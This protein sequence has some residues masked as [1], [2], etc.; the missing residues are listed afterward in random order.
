VQ[1][2]STPAHWDDRSETVGLDLFWLPLGAGGRSV[3]WNGRIF[4]GASALIE[5]RTAQELYHSALVVHLPPNRYVV[6][7]TPVWNV[8]SV[9]R[10]VVVE[11]PVGVRFAKRYAIGRY[12]VHCWKNG[13]IADVD[14]AVDSP[15]RLVTDAPSCRRA[16]AA[17]GAVP[18]L[19]WGRDERR[20]GEMWN[21]NSVVAWVLMR[22]G[23]DAASIHPPLHG[24]APGWTAGVVAG[25]F[26]YTEPTTTTE[27]DT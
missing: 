3:K 13:T 16:L 24:A 23:I 5:R 12:E 25:A 27:R 1:T 17:V 10:G 18:E 21:S 6:E 14:E 2:P 4:E 26:D 11:G 19:I 8:P 15:R 9:D 7:M 22:S 20:T